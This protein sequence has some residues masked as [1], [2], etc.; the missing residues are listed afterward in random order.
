MRSWGGG[1][2][3]RRNSEAA[4]HL[5]DEEKRSKAVKETDSPSQ[6]ARESAFRCRQG[7]NCEMGT[8]DANR[9]RGI[10]TNPCN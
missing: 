5:G 6:E 7:A 4:K 3:G 8:G 10:A 9:A 1:I 2:G